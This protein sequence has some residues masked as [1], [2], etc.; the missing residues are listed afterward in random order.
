MV[1]RVTRSS[2]IGAAP[3]APGGVRE[4]R[5]ERPVVVGHSLGG[6]L[7][8]ML[9]A[10]HPEI[11]RAAALLDAPVVP[12]PGRDAMM[13]EHFARLREEYD[14]EMRR[15]FA[16]FFAPGDGA[17]LQDRVMA[18]TLEPPR[19]AVIATWE[20]AALDPDTAASV[21]A[22]DIPRCTSAPARRPR[23]STASSSSAR[24]PSS[25]GPSGP[26]TSCNASSPTG[27]TRCST[28]SSR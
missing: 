25:A 10:T 26:G 20:R 18:A 1:G 23:C 14:A 15:Y 28:A 19:H 16:A 4:H 17:D 6:V 7:T 9:A 22:L 27:S 12:P 5:V 24:A 21:A 11:P 8:A 13:R 3:P 2:T